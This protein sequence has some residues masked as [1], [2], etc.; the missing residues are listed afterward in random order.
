[1]RT[2]G[3]NLRRV[4]DAVCIQIGDSSSGHFGHCFQVRLKVPVTR[5]TLFERLAIESRC[6]LN[7][8]LLA[9]GADATPDMP[10]FQIA[11]SEL[12]KRLERLCESVI[13]ISSSLSFRFEVRR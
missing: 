9:S 4:G 3:K 6:R 13:Y 8:R 12:S 5:A 2:Y 1:M 10:C 11:V 7:E